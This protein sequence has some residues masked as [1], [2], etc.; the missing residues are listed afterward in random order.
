MRNVAILPSAGSAPPATGQVAVVDYNRLEFDDFG[1]L[2]PFRF[3]LVADRDE[4][5]RRV[6]REAVDLIK[7]ANRKNQPIL[8]IV[9]VGPL[10]YTCWT[11]L[12]NE[13]G[14]SCEG[15]TTMCM[16]EYLDEEDRVIQAGHPLSFHGYI[17]RTLVEP[18]QPRLRPDPKNVRIPDPREPEAA[19]ALIE[20]FGG[21]D[22]CY[23]GMGITGHFAFNDPPEPGEPVRDEAVRSSRTRRLAVSR[24]S[25]TQ[26]AMGGVCGNWDI[27]PRRAVTLGMYELLLSKRIHLTFMR[28]WHSGVLRRA[29]FGPVTGACPGSFIQ[30]HGN[31]QVTITRLAARTP[32]CNVAQ[33]TGE[34]EDA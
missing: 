2:R 12:C 29:L 19:T 31:V 14:V 1:R 33:A 8:M 21:A 4:L 26:M 34:G 10:D 11:K 22:V 3:S 13:E 16:D 32:L 30:E 17:Q 20:A 15:L 6:A 23:G 25:T 18:L 7:A 28:A 27:L 5:N 9:P 24:E